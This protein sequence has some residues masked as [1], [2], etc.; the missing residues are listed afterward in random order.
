MREC[1]RKNCEGYSFN[2]CHMFFFD[3]GDVVLLL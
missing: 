1:L 3:D 2:S